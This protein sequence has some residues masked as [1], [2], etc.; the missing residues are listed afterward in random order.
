MKIIK[1]LL[2]IV[3]VTSLFNACKYNFI[4]PFEE[5]DNGGPGDPGD[6]DNPDNPDSTIVISF[7]NDIV[8][9]FNIGDYCTSCH[10]T[11]KQV[12]DLTVD[13]AFSSLNSSRYINSTTP[14]ES[15]I[16][17][18]THPDTST[19]TRKKYNSQQAAKVSQW[20][21]EGAKNN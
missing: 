7:K 3:V 17:K 19:H 11:G 2:A 16:Y 9:I 18:Y 10:I 13:K 4:V 21:K 8:P 5:P 20:I 1:L 15:K 12:L 6:P 14:E